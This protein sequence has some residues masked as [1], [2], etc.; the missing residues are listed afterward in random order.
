MKVSVVV[1]T[2]NRKKLLEKCLNQLSRQDYP[3]YEVI[4]VDDGSTD[5]TDLM[6]KQKFPQVV[7]VRQINK[8]P[9][10]ARNLG[11]KQA[12]GQ[13]VAFTDDDCFPPLD[14]LSKLVKGFNEHPDVV[15][16]GGY[17]EAS[18]NVLK[19]NRIA[20]YEQWQAKVIYKAGDKE[21]VGGF[22]CPA[23]GTCNMAYYKKVLDEVEGF[24]ENFPV[25][26][27]E[28]AD[29]KL[30]LTSR[31][32]KLL[33]IPVKVTHLDSYT[34]KDFFKRVFVRG[35]GQVVFETKH[36]VKPSKFKIAL[37]F[38]KRIIMLF[39]DITTLKWKF[40][41]LRFLDSLVNTAGQWKAS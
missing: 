1:P 26:A 40:A 5:G 18:E 17:L 33:Y 34:Y 29:L 37:R 25:P 19:K 28:D 30:R 15:G 2:Y 6:V 36:T 14:W 21:Y 13:I 27:G 23:G 12:T 24:D 16:V 32:Y 9:A 20:R 22:E 41:L 39:K 10:A 3:D 8:G 38:V 7:Y 31:G 35:I 4:V 11:I